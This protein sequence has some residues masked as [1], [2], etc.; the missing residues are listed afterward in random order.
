M[1]IHS[2]RK[3][4]EKSYCINDPLEENAR[5]GVIDTRSEWWK[6]KIQQITM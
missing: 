6:N 3:S 5:D 2:H 4:V 1:G